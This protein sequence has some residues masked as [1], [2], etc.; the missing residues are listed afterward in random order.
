MTKKY[1]KDAIRFGARVGDI[2]TII[3]KYPNHVGGWKNV[4]I[5]EMDRYIGRSGILTEI[6]EEGHYIDFGD[7]NHFGFP[8]FSLAFVR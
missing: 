8:W 7:N 4:W 1:L 2:V 6:Q 5:N 3:A